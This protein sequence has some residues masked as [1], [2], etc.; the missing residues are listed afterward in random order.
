MSDESATIANI[1]FDYTFAGRVFKLRK[2]N[3]RQVI[4]FQN[5]LATIIK[6]TENNA[7][8]DLTMVAEALLIS[9]SVTDP[10]IN[11]DYVLDNTP[12]DIGV[13]DTL[14]TLGFMSQQKV[15]KLNQMKDSLAEK[16][17]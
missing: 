12:G 9:L 7:S 10:S 4:Q 5:K 2:A 14:T 16:N 13:V 6:D 15:E 8:R 11:M 17:L 1:E 3:L